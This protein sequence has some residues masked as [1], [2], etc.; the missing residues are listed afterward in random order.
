ME[1]LIKKLVQVN[2][3]TLPDSGTVIK[4]LEITTIATELL[5]D[6]NGQCIWDLINYVRN[7]GFAVFPL[8][9]DSFGWILGG[10]QTKKGIISFG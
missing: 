9:E 8:E 5:I 7:C 1:S 10:I 2:N 3:S 4:H 6:E